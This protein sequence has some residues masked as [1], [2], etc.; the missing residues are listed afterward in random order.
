MYVSPGLLIHSANGPFG[1]VLDLVV[2]N[3]HPLE[4]GYY[5][6]TDFL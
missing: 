1:R 2:W 5:R 3:P 4:K 6:L